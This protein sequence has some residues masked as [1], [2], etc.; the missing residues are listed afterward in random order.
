VLVRRRKTV[1]T[2][3]FQRGEGAPSSAWKSVCYAKSFLP[4][5]P[6]GEEQKTKV[7]ALAFITAHPLLPDQWQRKAA[8]L[9]KHNRCQKVKNCC[10]P[11]AKVHLNKARAAMGWPNVGKV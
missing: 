7:T 3:D 4:A 1:G 6:S 11:G 10:L 9:L 8:T 2:K 5:S